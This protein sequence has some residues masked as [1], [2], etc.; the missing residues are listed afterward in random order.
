[1]K[2]ANRFIALTKRILS[3]KIYIFML[4]L[5]VALTVIYKLL[6]D[7][8]QSADIRVAMY[9]ED[10]T[11]YY[12]ELTSYLENLN[13]IYTFY[14]VDRE[15]DL[16][17]DVKSGHAECGYIIPDG[18]FQAY[19]HGEAWDIP[20]K[21][22]ITPSSTFYTAINETI[23]SS[24]LSV[25]AEDILLYSVNNPDWDNELA[26]GLEYYR[27][28]QDVFTI[29][30]NTS[31]EFS[32]DSMVYHIKLP[33]IETVSIILLFSGLLGLLL[34]LHDKEKKMYIAL[35]DREV[36]HIKFLT[37]TTSILPVMLVSVISLIVSYG[38]GMYIIF[39]LV[40]ALFSFFIAII[41]S[42][43][44]RK[45]TLLE[46]VLPLIMLTALVAVFIKTII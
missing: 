33:I 43:F 42:L 26:E 23:I 41:L 5:L 24:I 22:Y 32:F 38:I 16:L 30:D 29:A 8:S 19:V 18:F 34:F 36:R 2:S 1:M 4:L 25:C 20:M 31:G 40:V 28:S 15:E 7:K 37:I 35:N 21:L 14:T 39:G 45:S 9:S 11:G 46:K 17:N 6:P 10:S 27:N 3:K 44:I 12:E 13:S